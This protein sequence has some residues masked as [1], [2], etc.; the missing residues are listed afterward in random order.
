MKRC[1][2]WKISSHTLA[3][4]SSTENDVNI[5]LVKVW[6]TI[7]WKFDLFNQIKFCQIMAA[8]IQLHGCT[9]GVLTKH[10]EKKLDGNHTRMLHAVLNKSQKQYPTKQQLYSL[11]SPIS[12]TIQ[13]R[14]T[15][16]GA[17]LEKQG[18]THKQCFSM[19]PYTWLH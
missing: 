13:V 9:T 4:I 3:A 18:Q 10:T 14:Q 7:V 5:Y 12:K 2:N 19:D 8:L 17:L 15:K 1:Q 11:L 6:T 16:H